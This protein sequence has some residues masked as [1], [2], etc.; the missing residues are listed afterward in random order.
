MKVAAYHWTDA[1]IIAGNPAVDFVNTA[2]SESGEPLDRLGGPAAL[3]HWAGLAGLLGADDLSR[4]KDEIERDPQGAART[5]R[6]ASRLRAA[7]ARIFTASIENK[8]ADERDLD[9]LNDWKI[10]AAKHCGIR[11]T[12]DGFRRA[13]AD[14]APALE[15][16]LRLIFEAAEDLL[17]SGPLDRLK[18]CGGETCGWLFVDMSK[19]GRRRW[20]SM[21]TCGNEHKV[22][23]F[24]KRKKEKAA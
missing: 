8:R 23:A 12:G 19:N 10:R 1:D 2:A 4:L 6:D 21:A 11:Q 22:K 3:G 17:V 9:I 24:R 16:A 7:L 13:C 5:Y 18:I 20:C 15:R 14:E